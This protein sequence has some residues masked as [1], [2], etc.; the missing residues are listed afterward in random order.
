LAILICRFLRSLVYLLLLWAITSFCLIWCWI[1][2]PSDSVTLLS[3]LWLLAASSSVTILSWSWMASWNLP[4]LTSLSACLTMRCALFSGVSS[5]MLGHGGS[6]Y[7]AAGGG[8]VRGAVHSSALWRCT[9]VHLSAARAGPAVQALS[10][11]SPLKQGPTGLQQ[12][13]KLEFGRI[14]NI[15]VWSHPCGICSFAGN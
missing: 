11:G 15:C 12:L 9:T 1:C 6:E 4:C 7:A 8:P 2:R 14:R 13:L 5:S 10:P 3:L